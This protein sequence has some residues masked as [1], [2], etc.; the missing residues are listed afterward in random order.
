MSQNAGT[1]NPARGNRRFILLAIVLGLM[2]A[3]LVYVATSRNSTTTVPDT[4]TVQP[5]PVVVAKVD[6]PARTRITQ[7]M[8]DVKLLQPEALS[9]L[10]FTNVQTAVGQVTRYPLTVG[11]QVLS[12]KVVNVKQRR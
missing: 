11:E 9:P 7:E 4:S 3:G 12:T 8:L 10:A 2:G 5:V 1:L 6:I